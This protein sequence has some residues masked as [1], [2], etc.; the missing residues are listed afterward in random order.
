MANQPPSSTDDLGPSTSQLSEG[1]SLNPS[2]RVGEDIMTDRYTNAEWA[3]QIAETQ[4]N[5]VAQQQ[6]Y[7][8]P[9]LGSKE[10]A[11]TIDHTLLKLDATAAQIDTLCSEA[12]VEGFK[13]GVPA[14]RLS[15]PSRLSLLAVILWY[16]I[17]Y[18]TF[19]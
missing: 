19:M 7:A 11:Q 6:Y 14:L 10:F 17:F 2:A 16:S 1:Q 12:R 3:I 9:K 15:R 13:V 8:A 18:H 5:V 4:K